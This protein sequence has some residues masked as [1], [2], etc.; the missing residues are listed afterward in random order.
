MRVP[1]DTLFA[2]G[3]LV[4]VHLVLTSRSRQCQ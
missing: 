4:L 2:A 3:A 1:G